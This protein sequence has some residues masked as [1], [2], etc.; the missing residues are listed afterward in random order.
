MA[1]FTSFKLYVYLDCPFNNQT[2]AVYKKKLHL[3]NTWTLQKQIIY[4][5]AVLYKFAVIYD[6]IAFIWQLQNKVFINSDENIVIN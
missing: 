6:N 5:P 3:F 2:A 4:P 1:P